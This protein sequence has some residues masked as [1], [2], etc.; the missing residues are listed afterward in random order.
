MC[1]FN[2]L[3][4]EMELGGIC[5]S[6]YTYTMNNRLIFDDPY[7]QWIPLLEERSLNV[8][9]FKNTLQRKTLIDQNGVVMGFAQQ[10]IRLEGTL[11]PLQN[12]LIQQYNNY[13]TRKKTLHTTLYFGG[14]S[15]TCSNDTHI[16]R[17][18]R[19]W[20]YGWR[21][22]KWRLG[23]RRSTSRRQWRLGGVSNPDTKETQEGF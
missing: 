19:R 14:A 9:L 2:Y 5:G 3:V 12:R 13:E 18:R 15:D 17:R 21:R 6:I 22:R 8:R 20:W 23:R 16:S 4:D 7:T 11:S 1:L 10:I